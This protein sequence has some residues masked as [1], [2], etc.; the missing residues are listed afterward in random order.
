[1]PW[2]GYLVF[3]LTLVIATAIVVYLLVRRVRVDVDRVALAAS[4]EARTQALLEVERRKRKRLEEVSAE[5]ERKLLANREWFDGKLGEIDDELEDEY[6]SLL[7]DDDALLGRLAELLRGDAPAGATRE[8]PEAEEGP[9]GEYGR[10]PT[11][12]THPGGPP[13]TGGS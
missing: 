10:D 13:Q 1:M 11:D 12:P 5:L 9:T 6:N 7:A 3:G 2:W 4:R 8:G